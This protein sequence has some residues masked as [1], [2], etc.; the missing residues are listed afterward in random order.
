VIIHTYISG[1]R[2]N[3]IILMSSSEGDMGGVREKENV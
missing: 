2:E 3:K 1:E